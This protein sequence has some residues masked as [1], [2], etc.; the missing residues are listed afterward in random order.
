MNAANKNHAL[1]VLR[2]DMSFPPSPTFA[3]VGTL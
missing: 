3:Q 2:P 1:G